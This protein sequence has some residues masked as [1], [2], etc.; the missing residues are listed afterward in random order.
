MDPMSTTR[1]LSLPTHGALELLIGLALLAAPFAA[2]LGA[3]GLVLGVA[4]GTIVA[5]LGLAGIDALP[6][7]AHQALDQAVAT[8]LLGLAVAMAFAGE[9]TGAAVL[10]AAA[11]AELLLLAGTRWTRGR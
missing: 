10:G 9:A 11:I 4:A 2:G 5:G 3:G 1:R 6:L 8:I 7:G